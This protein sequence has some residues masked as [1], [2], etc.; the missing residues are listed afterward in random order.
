MITGPRAKDPPQLIVFKDLFS[1]LDLN[2]DQ[3]PIIRKTDVRRIES[4]L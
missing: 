4:I 2:K 3:G 1:Q